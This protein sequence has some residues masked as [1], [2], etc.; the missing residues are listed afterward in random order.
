M[1]NIVIIGNL[2]QDPE[3]RNLPDGTPVAGFSIAS[4]S[5]GKNPVTTWFRVNAFGAQ[6][7]PIVD[8]LKKGSKAAVVG[9][10]TQ[11]TFDRNDG[12]GQGTSLD[13]RATNVTFLDPKP[14][15]ETSEQ[16]AA[17]AVKDDVPF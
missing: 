15:A 2:G 6:A 7:Q 14:T 12:S 5:R 17:G 8:N 1:N 9:E 11:K 16:P 4:N 10:L 13:V 3:L